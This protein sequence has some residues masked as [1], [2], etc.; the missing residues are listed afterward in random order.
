MN[1][2]LKWQCLIP[3]TRFP[4]RLPGT[5]SGG[6]RGRQMRPDKSRIIKISTTNPSPPLGPSP[7]LRLCPPTGKRTKKEQYQEHNQNRV[8]HPK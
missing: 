1:E 4:V 5:T 7:Q 3:F 6:N 8:Q 2:P